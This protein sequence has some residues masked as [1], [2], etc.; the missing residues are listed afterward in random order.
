MRCRWW[1]RWH[2]C[3]VTRFCWRAGNRRYAVTAV[4]V[5]FVGLLFFEKAAVIPFVAFT[6]VA[7]LCHVRG[8]R[9]ALAEAWGRGARLWIP[10]LGLTAVWIAVYL[11]VVDQKRWSW[12]PPTWDL[13]SRSFTHGI[14]PGL[15]GAVGVAAVGSGVAVGDSSGRPSWSSAGC[16]WRLRWRSR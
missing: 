6:V 14:V 5:Y 10:A 9:K 8:D 2:G 1:R 7:L 11:V 15:A 16:R 4:L 13:L 12:D 3:V